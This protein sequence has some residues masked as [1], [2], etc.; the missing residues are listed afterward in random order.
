MDFA[1][2]EYLSRTSAFHIFGDGAA[3]VPILGK[4]IMSSV[5]VTCKG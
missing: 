5:P 4:I 1:V 2:T 3:S